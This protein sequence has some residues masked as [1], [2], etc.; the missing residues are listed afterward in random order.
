MERVAIIRQAA[1]QIDALIQDLLDI[2]RLEAGRLTVQMSTEDVTSVVTQ[3]IDGMR[4]LAEAGGVSLSAPQPAFPL[5]VVADR[6]RLCQLLSNLVG[7]AIKFTPTGGSVSL[8]VTAHDEDVEFEI[9][10]T[11][12]GIQPDQLPYVFDRFYQAGTGRRGSRHGAGL[13]L[14][15]SRGIVE[16]HGGRI[17]LESVASGGTTVRFTLRRADSTT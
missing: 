3:C 10:D 1:D 11:G 5:S 9:T 15:I 2:T 4:P 12:Q 13:G 6:D 17:W 7:N 14:P 8:M 16:A